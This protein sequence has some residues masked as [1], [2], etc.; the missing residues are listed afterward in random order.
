MSQ[1]REKKLEERRRL[2]VEYGKLFESVSSL[3]SRHDPVGINFETNTDE[4]D[5]EVG[6]ILPRLRTCKTAADVR[7]V[8]H[9]EFVRWFDRDIAGPKELYSKIAEEIW[10]LWKKSELTQP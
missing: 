9:E 5:P 8:V 2:K 4:Y 3:L 1:E 6:T 7:Q 10:Q